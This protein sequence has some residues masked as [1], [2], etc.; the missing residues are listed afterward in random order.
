MT[1]KKSHE[2]KSLPIS[3]LRRVSILFPGDLYLLAVWLMGLNYAY[4]RDHPGSSCRQTI[5]GLA[6]NFQYL[7]Y[8]KNPT[9]TT[10]AVKMRIAEAG[11]P[12]DA[13][14]ELDE[15]ID[16]QSDAPNVFPMPLI[17]T[18]PPEEQGP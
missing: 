4:S 12:L 17:G 10:E 1:R 7:V 18:P 13:Q 8:S 16:F 3:Q 14:I 6:T 11:L 9:W 15:N 2:L 5:H